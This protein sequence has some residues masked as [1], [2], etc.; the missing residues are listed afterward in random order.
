MADIIAGELKEALYDILGE[1]A[2]LGS[3]FN[4]SMTMRLL[5]GD[6]PDGAV[7]DW[8]IMMGNIREK[9]L[10]TEQPKPNTF[11][12]DETK[13]MFRKNGGYIVEE[14]EMPE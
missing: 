7:A 12:K 9:H 10:Q 3:D 5:T 1:E 14:A 4:D 2:T 13:E 8:I 6:M 11:S